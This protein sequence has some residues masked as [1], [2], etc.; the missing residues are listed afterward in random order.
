M[1][2]TEGKFVF[3]HLI[4]KSSFG[5][6]QPNRRNREEVHCGL[7]LASSSSVSLA[8]ILFPQTALAVGG[9]QA[10]ND[11]SLNGHLAEGLG[12]TCVQEPFIE[13]ESQPSQTD[14]NRNKRAVF[15]VTSLQNVSLSAQS[16]SLCLF[17]PQGSHSLASALFPMDPNSSCPPTFVN[18]QS[19]TQSWV[20]SKWA[21][22]PVYDRW[23]GCF[24]TESVWTCFH[25]F[26]ALH[27]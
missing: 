23:P 20:E 22:L 14:A 15:P 19:P 7:D 21:L 17:V 13:T 11:R 24:I 26:K 16:A 2:L 9:S 25:A 1:N 10:P 18:K 6:S 4:I 12:L 27:E 8:I 3:F 5:P